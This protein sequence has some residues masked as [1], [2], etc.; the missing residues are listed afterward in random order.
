M[1]ETRIGVML[2]SMSMGMLLGYVI[3]GPLTRKERREQLRGLI[4]W[5][6]TMPTFRFSEDEIRAMSLDD[7]QAVFDELRAGKAGKECI[8]WRA[9]YAK[10]LI[11]KL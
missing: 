11:E 5:V 8:K 1:D 9:K 3:W 7:F 4:G 10:I 2:F 6:E